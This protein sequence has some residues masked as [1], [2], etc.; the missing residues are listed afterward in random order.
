MKTSLKYFS[1]AKELQALAD[2]LKS[3]LPVVKSNEQEIFAQTNNRNNL[4]ENI[5]NIVL[6][7]VHLMQGLILF[8]NDQVILFFFISVFE[9]KYYYF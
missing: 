3:N 4:L 7:H 6:Q 9:Y 2:E 1:K 8:G 5:A